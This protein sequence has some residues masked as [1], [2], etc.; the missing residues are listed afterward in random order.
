M[1]HRRKGMDYY[2]CKFMIYRKL[3]VYS[4]CIERCHRDASRESHQN[5][6]GT[7]EKQWTIIQEEEEEEKVQRDSIT[8]KS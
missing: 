3:T 8:S 2:E 6:Q 5:V 1:E 4:T 7:E